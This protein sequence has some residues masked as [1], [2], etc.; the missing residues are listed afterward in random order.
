MGESDT[1]RDVTNAT[2]PAPPRRRR[3][4][5]VLLMLA[6]FLS[7]AV[8]GG[9]LTALHLVR[10]VRQAVQRPE[11]RPGRSAEWIARRLD[12]TPEQRREVRDILHHHA[13]E[14]QR[15]RRDVMPEVRE[16]L[17][18]L[19]EEIAG[20]LTPE[21]ERRWREITR[22]TRLQ[23]MPG[24]QEL[25]PERVAP[26]GPGEGPRRRERRLRPESRP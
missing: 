19:E 1:D 11:E 26:P 24:A 2:V 14:M 8:C 6:L 25:P 13:Q 15:I 12:L 9:G 7:G 18:A 16:Q 20:V 4:L 5:T 10:K 17:K 21:Q 3:W 23:W 22:R